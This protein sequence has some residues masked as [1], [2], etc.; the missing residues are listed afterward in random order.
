M[1]KKDAA[2]SPAVDHMEWGIFRKGDIETSVPSEDI[3]YR[4]RE[5]AEKVIRRSYREPQ[6]WEVRGRAVGP[7]DARAGDAR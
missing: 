2:G 3:T 4:T 5:A 7:W 1:T 6:Y